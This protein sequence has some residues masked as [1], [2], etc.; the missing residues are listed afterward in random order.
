MQRHLSALS[1][2]VHRR[3]IMCSRVQSRQLNITSPASCYERSHIFV[4]INALR[5]C[6]H[7]TPYVCSDDTQWYGVALC[8]GCCAIHPHARTATCP[9]VFSSLS[10]LISHSGTNS[11][12]YTLFIHHFLPVCSSDAVR[13]V[14]LLLMMIVMATVEY[15]G[16]GKLA[17]Y[18]HGLDVR[19]TH[20]NENVY[21]MWVERKCKMS[22]TRWNG[23]WFV[24]SHAA[25]PTT[26]KRSIWDWGWSNAIDIGDRE[27]Q[28]SIG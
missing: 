12:P 17:K 7:V 18:I 3:C 8:Q 26:T 11:I 4:Q 19:C 9:R 28:H 20:M 13:C 14:V 24:R 10:R 2:S 21:E 22:N 15:T 5:K 25:K 23:L 16:I 6:I 1:F 27:Q